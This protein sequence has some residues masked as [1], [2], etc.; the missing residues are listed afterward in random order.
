VF[1]LAGKTIG[2]PMGSRPEFA[3]SRYLLFRGIDESEVTL[4][5]VKIDQSVEAISSGEVDAV[6]VWEPYTSRIKEQMGGGV[7]SWS[8]QED[9]PSYTLLMTTREYIADHQ[10]PVAA[11]L[12]ALLQA[13]AYIIENPEEAG[14]IIRQQMSY[15]REYIDGIWPDYRFSISLNQALVVAMEDQARWIIKRGIAPEKE[16]PNF[17]EHI[18]YTCLEKVKPEAVT[19][20]R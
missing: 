16:T 3:L 4:V 19:I 11:F 15:S 9:Q 13:E 14:E 8:V 18:C 10:E 20:I 12:Q 2:L 7:I 17:L 6:A 5:D 1:D